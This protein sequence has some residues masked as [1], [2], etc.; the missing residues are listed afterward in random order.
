MHSF[1]PSVLLGMAG[2]DAFDGDSQTQPQ[3]ESLLSLNKEFGEAKGTPLSERIARGRPLSEAPLKSGQSEIFARGFESF[4]QQQV[5]RRMI[6]V[7]QRIALR[8][9][10]FL[11]RVD[12]R[13]GG[14][15][16]G[17][18]DRARREGCFW[19]EL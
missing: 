1:M 13:V 10:Q 12:V 11:A 2:T 19:R 14:P 4:A 3:T 5:T 16:P 8:K 6:G 18:G 15:A 9:A 17:R 7:G